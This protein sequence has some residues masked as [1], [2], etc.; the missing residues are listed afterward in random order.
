MNATVN[1][2]DANDLAGGVYVVCII[3]NF[4]ELRKGWVPCVSHM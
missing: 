4:L 3:A 2:K 1:K